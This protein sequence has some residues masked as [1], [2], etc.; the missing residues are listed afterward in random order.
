MQIKSIYLIGI[1][2]LVPYWVSSQSTSP[3]FEASGLLMLHDADMHAT[4]FG[5][6]FWTREPTQR[7][8]FS[9][10]S[11]PLVQSNVNVLR[12]TPAPN[13][14]V[15]TGKS[16][17]IHPELKMAYVLEHRASLPRDLTQISV[18][19]DMEDLPA[20]EFL[21]LV[22]F[23]DFEAP[24]AQFKM[25]IA[26][27]ASS[28]SLSPDHQYLAITASEDEREV[29][30]LE[31]SDDGRPIR[32]ITKPTLL[33]PGKL[34]DIQ[35]HPSGDYLAYINAT[36]RTVGVLKVIRDGPTGK[37]IRIEH[38]DQTLSVGKRPVL[39]KFTPDGTFFF[40]MDAKK[41]KADYRQPD[42][43]EL[44]AVK[45]NPDGA[46]FLLSRC[47]LGENPTD[48]AIHPSG[49]WIAAVNAEKSYILGGDIPTTSAT[50]HVISISPQGNLNTLREIPLEGALPLSVV[51]DKTGR[52]LVT[53][54]F[55]IQS[56]GIRVGALDF[57]R[58]SEANG[59]PQLSPQNGKVF[60]PRGVHSIVPI[61]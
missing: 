42:K 37:I 13:S 7:D 4:T 20:G 23:S 60:V 2:S 28:I 31:L 49:Q 47:T 21:T 22:D 25:P 59:R 18:S 32:I 56:F 11:F 54:Q 36:N 17:A 57:W 41:S 35:W 44:F 46:H 6:G 29:E 40:I 53:S 50:M 9:T 26:K 3:Q 45:L 15:R 14:S 43:G 19:A 30:I 38:G 51:W 1:L 48:L 61:P 34:V 8:L 27:N 55:E 10:L 39:G 12:S 58:W 33:P 5:Q 24:K 52:H 16:V